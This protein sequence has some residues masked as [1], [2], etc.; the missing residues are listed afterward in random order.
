MEMKKLI[1]A[2]CVCMFLSVPVAYATCTAQDFQ[3]EVMDL[4][5]NMTEL[6]KDPAKVAEANEALEKEFQAEVMEF[7]KMAQNAAGDPAKAQ[8]MLDKG[9]DLYG[10]M[11][12][13]LNEFK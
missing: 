1:L 10:R 6:S 2:V 3:K 9:C 11:N 12:K 7:A 8:E 5:T 13:R 4:Q